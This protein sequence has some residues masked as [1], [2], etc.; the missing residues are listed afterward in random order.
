M[1]REVTWVQQAA[2]QS[3]QQGVHKVAV[4]VGAFHA[5]CTV[6]GCGLAVWVGHHDVKHAVH[7]QPAE[8]IVEEELQ[9]Q[10]LLLLRL[11]HL[12]CG[13]L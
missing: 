11:M 1:T 10:A 6:P 8:R 13:N 7:I 4:Q 3:L 12:L 9:P 5:L 2:M